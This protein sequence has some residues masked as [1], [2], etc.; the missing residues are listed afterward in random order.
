[1]AERQGFEPWEDLRPLLISNQVRSAAPAPL[2]S[3]Y[4]SLAARESGKP[5]SSRP[6]AHCQPLSESL[7]R[8]FDLANVGAMVEID[9][10]A[11]CAF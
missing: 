2:L 6:G 5:D 11:D 4:Y 1:M 7:K 8:C 9:Q 3:G 10:A